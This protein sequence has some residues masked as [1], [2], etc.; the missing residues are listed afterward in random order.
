MG[1]ACPKCGNLVEGDAKVLL[2]HLQHV[3]GI[4][5]GRTFTKSIQCGQE[6]CLRSFS[7]RTQVFRRHLESDHRNNELQ[8]M[9]QPFD[10]QADP[11]DDD[12]NGDHIHV[13]DGEHLQYDAAAEMWDNF[14]AE[15]LQERA[16]MLISGLLGSS[17]VTHSAVTEVVQNTSSLVEDVC[18]YVKHRVQGFAAATG[19]NAEEE[20]LQ[21][22]VHDIENVS[23][24]FSNLNTEYKQKKFFQNSALFVQ[25]EELP[26]GI[27]YFPQNNPETGNV[28]QVQKTISYQYVP[29]ESQL[30]VLL[31]NTD[32]LK[33]A[34]EYTPSEDGLMRDMHDGAY[35]KRHIFFSSP[36][37]LKL[38]LYIDDLEVTNPLSPK[39]GTHKLGV[40]YFTIG[41]VP[42]E[43]R[44]VLSNVFLAML[45]NSSDAKMYGYDP[46]FSQFVEDMKKLETHG[47]RVETEAFNGEVRAGIFQVVGDNLGIHSLF[48]FAEGFT[49]NYPC[50]KCKAHRNEARTMTMEQRDLLRTPEN[51]EQDLRTENLQRTG[52]KTGCCLN[53]LT[54]FHVL[55][56]FAPDI[57]H[58]VLEGIGPL[59]FKLI[60]NELI[61]KGCFTLD[62][63]NARITSYNYGVP[64]ARNKPCTYTMQKLRSPDGGPG[65]KA[66][67]TWCLLR[68]IGLMLGDL[69]T[70]GDEHWELLL[71]LCEVMDIL[72]STVISQ[73]DTV[74]VVQLIHDHH[75]LF[76]E[77]F[78]DRHLKPK[79]H[80]LCHYAVA[81]KEIGPLSH[82]WTMRFEAKH[83]FVRRLSHIICNFRNVA[84]TLAFR[85]Q[86]QLCHSIMCK[87]T[88]SER[89]IEIGPGES[90]ILASLMNAELLQAVLEIPLYDEVFIAKWCK[91]YGTDYRRNLVVAVGNEN[92]ENH[93][94]FGK[95][96]MVA[97]VESQAFLVC[98]VFQTIGFCRHYHAYAVH[99][100]EPKDIRVVKVEDLIDFY[101]LHANK[102]YAVGD[103]TYYISIRHKVG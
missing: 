83:N 30:K 47:L 97:V 78:P 40:V 62:T 82:F 90:V 51:Y 68:H 49:A 74:Y 102:S 43:H 72:F 69:V 71:Q 3:H 98:D 9:P 8:F 96:T 65:Q 4:I 45:F 50:R 38:I 61:N 27:G 41:N 22:L 76:L 86:M 18:M 55:D 77:L 63:L 23:H 6:G 16:A 101:P 58:D 24:P 56:N 67:Q 89:S 92:Q 75:A 28:Q 81:F 11:D 12:G 53:E 57:M 39:A 5:N 15:E 73:E 52:I 26:L 91:V 99:P 79:H 87:H 88:M 44:S 34:S 64:D 70:E 2:W 36:N 84:K 66:G 59:E 13:H 20:N 35:C 29:I 19:M 100:Q 42:P 32:L 48:G 37:T 93:P 17:S 1:Y 103:N 21:A 25:P 31:E 95:I 54:H 7:G 33:I 46:I 14:G 60:M 80:F 10:R 85:S 94:M